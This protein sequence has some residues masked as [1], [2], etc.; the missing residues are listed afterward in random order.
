M[1]AFKC[2]RDIYIVP[3][4]WTELSCDSKENCKFLINGMNKQNVFEEK[5]A[6]VNLQSTSPNII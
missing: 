2:Q 1:I 5:E 3:T 4:K 6:Y